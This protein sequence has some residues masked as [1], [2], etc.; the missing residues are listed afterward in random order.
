MPRP[1]WSPDPDCAIA[2][3]VAVV[4]EGWNV[5][6]VREV[7]RGRHRFDELATDLRISRKV[8][9]ERLTA[10]QA[11]GV[12]RRDPYQHGPTRY[13]Y[14]LTPR[15]RALLPVLVALQDWGD[16][17]LLGDGDL[18]AT[19]ADDDAEVRRV[20]G[21]V[22]TRVPDLTLVATT[23]ASL[24]VV[25]PEAA[26]TVLFGYPATG[27]PGP[28]PDGWADIPGAAGCTLENRLFREAYPR[29]RAAGVAVRGFSTQRPD[30]QRAFAA[31]EAI[32]FP[33]LSDTELALVAGLR[34]PTFRAADAPRVKRVVLVVAAD[35]TVS[36]V[37]Y[38][39]TD[40][41]AAVDWALAESSPSVGAAGHSAGDNPV[42]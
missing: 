1:S 23:A 34:L 19:A 38:P 8:L 16:R 9:T 33:L 25:D 20:Q 22:G 18:T 5:L 13:A 26:R 7:A 27:I 32:P 4:G 21:L 35:R 30:E 39:V 12:L 11:A 41:P 40:I 37:R 28:L 42:A 31:A 29:L 10:L 24:D 6:I 3:A 36:A 14:R 17:W 2:Q 15:G